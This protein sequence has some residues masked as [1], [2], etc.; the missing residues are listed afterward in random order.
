MADFDK[1]FRKVRPIVL[2]L[3]RLYYLH[4][5]EYDDWMQ[6]GQLV[7]FQ[8]LERHPELS[9]DDRKLAIYFKTKFSNYIKDKIRQQESQKRKF[10]R[11]AYEEIGELAH[12][13][14]SKEMLLDDYVAY[15][16]SLSRLEEILNEEEKELLE[17]AT[18][19]ECFAGKK[20][21]LRKIE[22]YLKWFQ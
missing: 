9:D 6:E 21:F 13:L 19:G 12:S 5:W 3:R 4:L 14:A 18:C 8:L 17:R 11:M 16:D 15:Q 22:P 7:L 20:A 10:N 1:I 2:K